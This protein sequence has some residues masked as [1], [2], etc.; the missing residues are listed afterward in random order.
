MILAEGIRWLLYSSNLVSIR[1]DGKH[2][3]DTRSVQNQN[4]SQLSNKLVRNGNPGIQKHHRGW[5]KFLPSTF[6]PLRI[7]KSDNS[8]KLPKASGTIGAP[9]TAALLSHGMFTVSA[10]SR[11]SSTATFPPNV[12]IKRAD[13]TSHAQLVE[14]FQG[15]DVVI[16]ALNDE[17]APLQPGIIEAAYEAGVRRFL[18]NEWANHDSKF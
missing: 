9:I 16:C 12:L 18:V 5:C 10:L 13:L 17:A 15:Q 8:L 3:S 2:S 6:L 7:H 4:N 14:A 1:T 11:P